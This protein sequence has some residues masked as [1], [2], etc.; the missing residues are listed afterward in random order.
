LTKPPLHIPFA[1]ALLD[2]NGQVLRDPCMLELTQAEQTWTFEQIGTQPVPSLLHG[3]CAP[4]RVQYDYEDGEL[5]LLARHSPDPFARWEAGQTLALRQI[6]QALENPPENR[7]DDAPAMLI[8]TWQDVLNNAQL[9]PAYRARALTLPAEKI[10]LA[11]MQPMQPQRVAQVRQALRQQLGGTL[12]QDWLRTYREQAE[13][14]QGAYQADAVSDGVGAGQRALKNLALAYLA[15]GQHPQALA[16]AH[17]QYET[18]NNLTDRLAALSA[19]LQGP[20]TAAG[21]AVLDDFY[22]R[23]QHDPLIVDRWFSLQAA[24]PATDVAAVRR[25]MQHPA[26]TLRT[27]NRARALVFQFCLNNLLNVHTPQGYAFWAEQVLA[28]DA[29]NPEIAA[30]LARAFD[31]WAQYAPDLREAVHAALQTI[32]QH[33]ALSKNTAEIVM[34]S[35]QL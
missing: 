17:T 8:P 24:A 23:W 7:A 26:F 1:L 12:A 22:R 2:Q 29:I 10:I 19:L 15:A 13:K 20:D 31:N 18:A 34:K 35:L 16:L 21:Q 27:P 5:A 33:P 11:Y 32:A 28:L 4:V 6:L 30:R 9:T 25:L 3:F 14:Q